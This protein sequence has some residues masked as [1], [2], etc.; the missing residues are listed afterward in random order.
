MSYCPSPFGSG[1]SVT[2]RALT[3][4]LLAVCCR[5]GRDT[6]GCVSRTRCV[7][8]IRGAGPLGSPGWPLYRA[9][10]RDSALPRSSKT[11][12]QGSRDTN[13]DWYQG[14][15]LVCPGG[16]G[17]PPS[18]VSYHAKESLSLPVELR[19]GSSLTNNKLPTR[20]RRMTERSFTGQLCRHPAPNLPKPRVTCACERP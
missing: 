20:A 6:T 5:Q 3:G 13:E 1:Q 4:L 2:H 12:W 16:A 11:G 18:M 10:R 15:P 9:K 19:K 17:P 14:F 8:I 7:T